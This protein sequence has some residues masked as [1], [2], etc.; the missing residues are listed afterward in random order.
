M[1]VRPL[2]PAVN[3]PSSEPG[4]APVTLVLGGVRS[5]KSAFAERLT[6]RA[7]RPVY[8]AT[9]E[10]F[11]EEMRARVERHRARRDARW[12][13]LEEP[14]DLA[15]AIER[16]AAPEAAVLVDCLTV[17][18]GNLLHHGAD[19]D[20]AV[21]ALLE[22][23]AAPAGPVVLVSSEVGLGGVPDNALARAFAD[24]AGELNQAVAR[25]AADVYLTVAGIATALKDSRKRGA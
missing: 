25:C 2:V 18:L 7:A 12:S 1:S 23:L 24:R 4:L 14:I 8:L 19:L 10:I 15:G 22:S 16:A 6:L 21:G 3:E 9:A 20:A 13:T 17:W 11:D 5:G